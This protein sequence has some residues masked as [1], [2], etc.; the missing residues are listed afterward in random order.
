[1]FLVAAGQPSLQVLLSVVGPGFSRT[2]VSASYYCTFLVGAKSSVQGCRS[3]RCSEV[4]SCP[5]GAR[6]LTRDPG[7]ADPSQASNAGRK[8]K[9]EEKKDQL[10]S[11]AGRLA[12]RRPDLEVAVAAA[13]TRVGE[14]KRAT[15]FCSS[16]WPFGAGR[17]GR[18]F[19]RR[20]PSLRLHWRGSRS[21]GEPQAL[22]LWLLHHS[23]R[24]WELELQKDKPSRKR[25]SRYRP[26]CDSKL[27]KGGAGVN[28]FA[29]VLEK[30]LK[31]V[32]SETSESTLE[33]GSRLARRICL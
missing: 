27:Q 7:N 33:E 26:I 32:S 3:A 10:E 2:C 21:A 12:S 25:T 23:K 22:S 28:G 24:M 30:A 16:P 14:W 31:R 29:A 19:K 8:R 17:C 1:M 4:F 6:D 5:A 20:Q 9:R 13:V 18:V 15:K 11:P